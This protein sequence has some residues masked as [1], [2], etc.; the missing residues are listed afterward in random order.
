MDCAIA[1]AS[2]GRAVRV[3]CSVLGVSRSHVTAL[4]K[5]QSTWSDRR[6]APPKSDDSALLADIGTV[7]KDLD[8]VILKFKY[9]SRKL[10][11]NFRPLVIS[12]STRGNPRLKEMFCTIFSLKI[13]DYWVFRTIVTGHSGLS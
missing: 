12:E 3:V 8:A 4:A 11:A 10:V 9:S 5:R 1:L 7:I 2:R 13:D 6:R